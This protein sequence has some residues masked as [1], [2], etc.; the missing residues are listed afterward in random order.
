MFNLHQDYESDEKFPIQDDRVSH[1]LPV[2]CQDKIVRVYSKEADLVEAV[3]E[4]FE[5]FQLKTLGMKAQVH[6]TPDKKK[7]KYN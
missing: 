7:R 4:A 6:A 2:C 3:S 1:M 5:N